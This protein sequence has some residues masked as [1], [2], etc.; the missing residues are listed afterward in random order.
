MKCKDCGYE[1]DRDVIAC[2][3]LLRMREPKQRS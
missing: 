2:L 1:N 3:N